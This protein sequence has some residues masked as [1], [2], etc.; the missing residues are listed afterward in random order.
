MNNLNIVHSSD[1]TMRCVFNS[2]VIRNDSLNEKYKGGL[3]GFLKIHG[4]LVNSHISIICSMGDEIDEV[5]EDLHKQGLHGG[6]DFVFVDAGGY[7]MQVALDRDKHDVPHNINVGVD[8][9]GPK[10]A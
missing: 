1:E 8:W 3:K 4:A 7:S 9:L 2:V 5:L 6:P 10:Q